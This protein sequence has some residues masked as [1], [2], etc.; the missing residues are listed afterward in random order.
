MAPTSAPRA[1]VDAAP[2]PLSPASSNSDEAPQLLPPAWPAPPATAPVGVTLITGFLGSGKSTLVRRILTEPHGKRVLVVENEFGDRVSSSIESAVIT[3]A[4]G[5]PSALAELVSLPNGCVCCAASSDLTSS[6]A[7]LLRSG[8]RFDHVVVEAS[9]LADP[10]PVAAAFWVDE[11]LETMLRLD[12]VVGVVDAAAVLACLRGPDASRR[13]LAEKQVAVADV[14]LLNKVDLVG[15]AA[16]LDDVRG[17]VRALAA[18]GVRVAE[19]VRCA[20][21]LDDILDVRAYDPAAAGAR[22]V[23]GASRGMG[24]VVHVRGVGAV[25]LVFEGVQFGAAELDRALGA[26]LWD[27]GRGPDAGREVWRAKALVNVRGSENAVLYQA[28]HTLY[29]GEESDVRWAEGEAR[30]SRFVFIGRGVEEAHVRS[31]LLAAVV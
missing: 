26:L 9:G 7:R 31:V 29:E 18:D 12:A 17:A 2:P 14:V 4:A 1:L 20:V 16:A 6:L 25:S 13:R 10:G 23:L 21:G 19:C 28:V 8:R 24:D 22:A 3:P 27:D 11:Q 15:S 30:V 5:G